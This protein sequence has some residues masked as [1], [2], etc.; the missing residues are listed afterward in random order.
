MS[1][2][3]LASLL[4]ILLLIL[5]VGLLVT[6]G[7]WAP[8]FGDPAGPRN[9]DIPAS[10]TAPIA[11]TKPDLSPQTHNSNSE[12]VIDEYAQ[13]TFLLRDAT[14]TISDNTIGTLVVRNASTSEEF[15]LDTKYE[16]DGLTTMGVAPSG[17]YV[18]LSSGTSVERWVQIFR[19]THPAEKLAAM[20]AQR[21][22]TFW[23][24]DYALYLDCANNKAPRPW[25]VGAPNI[26]G[27]NLLTG[28][29]STLVASNPLSTYFSLSINDGTLSY[30]VDSVIRE[31]D[32]MKGEYLNNAPPLKEGTSTLDI[33]NAFRAHGIY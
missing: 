14:T 25:E 19:L 3:T 7:T 12:Q 21:R 11:K 24:T 23:K 9:S 32:W 28:A 30:I 16:D 5:G 22:V 18:Q 29:T 10:H 33:A 1:S 20:C 4:V 8:L 13:Y 27:L 31:S 17:R 26:I 2:K 6:E 15:V